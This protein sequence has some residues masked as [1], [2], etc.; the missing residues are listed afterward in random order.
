MPYRFAAIA[1]LL[2]PSIASAAGFVIPVAGS[3]SLKIAVPDIYAPSADPDG[4]GQMI[5]EQVRTN[6]NRTGYFDVVDPALILERG[7][8][9][10]PGEFE[11]GNWG[12]TDTLAKVRFYP[13]GDPACDAERWCAD[14]FIYY[15]GD[16]TKLA[17]KRFRATD[18]AER[19]VA[20]RVSDTILKA[21]VGE[22]GFFRGRI[23][24]V[25]SG[26]GNK[27]IW[28]LAMDGSKPRAMTRNGSINLSPAWSPDGARIA[29]T[30]FKDGNPNLYVKTLVSGRV[31]ALSTHDG[32]NVAPAWSPDGSKIALTRSSGPHSNIWIIDARTGKDLQQVTAEDGIDVSPSWSPDGSTLVWSSERAGGSQIYAMDMGSGRVRRVTRVA[33]FFTDP[34]FSPDGSKLAMVQRSGRFDIVVLDMGSGTLRRV[35]QDQGD[36]QDPTWSPDGRYLLFTSNRTGSSDLWLSTVNGRHQSRITRSG[37]WSQPDW[38]P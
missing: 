9:V 4:H 15:V 29:W 16:E 33:G 35:T 38:S 17:A 13:E 6:L 36:N 37:G 10:E 14:V 18:G 31:Q 26:Q 8:G 27:E 28:A 12:M 22:E 24:A 1:A 3:K 23:T 21:I 7:V 32:I 11:F 34:V 20:R 2:L 30:S 5:V 25:N 19:E